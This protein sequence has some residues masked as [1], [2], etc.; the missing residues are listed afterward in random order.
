MSDIIVTFYRM[1][2]CGF[3]RKFQPEWDQLV[4]KYGREVSFRVADSERD[5]N[6]MRGRRI[7]NDLTGK[8]EP[9]TGFPTVTIQMDGGKERVFRYPGD[10]LQTLDQRLNYLLGEQGY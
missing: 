7:L 1:E 2:G 5:Q 3:C 9:I 4:N 6:W 8:T 10:T